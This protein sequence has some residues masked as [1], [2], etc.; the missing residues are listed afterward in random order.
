M[1]IALNFLQLTP[2]PTG[3]GDGQTR[4]RAYQRRKVRGAVVG[5]DGGNERAAN[6]QEEV[7]CHTRIAFIARTSC[8]RRIPLGRW[9]RIDAPDRR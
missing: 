1:N 7:N 8:L 4:K 6:R 3:F 2:K 9:C 5:H